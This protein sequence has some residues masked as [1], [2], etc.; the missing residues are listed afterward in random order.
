[1]K[2]VRARHGIG[3]AYDRRVPDARRETIVIVKQWGSRFVALGIVTLSLACGS[4]NAGPPSGG[5]SGGDDGA[6][7]TQDGGGATDDA[8]EASESGTFD[9]GMQGSG[10]G[11]ASTLVSSTVFDFV[12]DATNVYFTTTDGVYGV[13]KSGGTPFLI[14]SPPA[15]DAGTA[16]PRLIILDGGTL[17]WNVSSSGGSLTL[18]ST[19]TSARGAAPTT[20]ISYIPPTGP[21]PSPIGLAVSGGNLYGAGNCNWIFSV[22]K[23]GAGQTTDVY[24]D[25]CPRYPSDFGFALDPTGGYAYLLDIAQYIERVRLSDGTLTTIP[26]QGAIGGMT[27]AGGALYTVTGSGANGSRLVRSALDG[28]SPTTIGQNLPGP[29]DS[30]LAVD[31]ANAYFAYMENPNVQEADVVL[32][33]VSVSLAT[34]QVTTL[35][36]TAPG[37][38]IWAM[39]SDD[40]FLYVDL[41]PGGILRIAK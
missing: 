19:P 8:S 12:L 5:D 22:P 39:A 4:T 15:V 1:M 30:P 13:P 36:T 40:A 41:F 2:R 20:I 38:E 32:Q 6:S 35:Y 16:E 11:G 27:I 17:Y 23:A 34:G 10:D 18:Q 28:T 9:A 21:L 14:A 29:T 24:D 33:L 31:G 26:L 37:V 25:V 3:F 7:R